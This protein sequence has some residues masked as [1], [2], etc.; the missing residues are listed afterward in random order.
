[1]KGSGVA[2]TK[3]NIGPVL[4]VLRVVSG[5][6]TCDDSRSS[7]EVR[8]KYPKMCTEM[9]PIEFRNLADVAVV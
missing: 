3:V 5:V 4:V 8:T 6:C 2:L 7:Y 9:C 1:M